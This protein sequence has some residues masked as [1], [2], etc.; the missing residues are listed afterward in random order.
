MMAR[1]KDASNR[2][3]DL[4]RDMARDSH[5]PKESDN[6]RTVRRYLTLCRACSECMDTFSAAWRNYKK[7]I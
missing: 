3:G 2:Y 1:Y 7:G 5:F 6:V 4:A